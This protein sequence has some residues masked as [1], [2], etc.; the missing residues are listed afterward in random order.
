M[1]G[2]GFLNLKATFALREKGMDVTLAGALFIGDITNAGLYRY[3]IREN[4]PVKEIK[5]FII[6]H[7]L[8][9]GH[10]MRKAKAG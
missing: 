2:G 6:N 4:K 3:V 10:F 8:H 1:A 7:N 5:P 9:Y